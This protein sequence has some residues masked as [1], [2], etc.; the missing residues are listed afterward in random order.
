[1]NAMPP[2]WYPD[3]GLRPVVR[4]WDGTRWTDQTLSASTT[5]DSGSL[6][7][8]L[9]AWGWVLIAVVSTALLAALVTTTVVPRLRSAPHSDREL[10]V[11]TAPSDDPVRSDVIPELVLPPGTT[12]IDGPSSG[13]V[14]YWRV[15]LPHAEVVDR[16][17][18][19]LPVGRPYGRLAWCGES[20]S[21]RPP[22]GSVDW[23]WGTDP[24]YLGVLIQHGPQPDYTRVSIGFDGSPLACHR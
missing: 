14:E 4:Y 9:P 21:D 6:K 20:V 2:G 23:M 22:N 17:R 19:Q 10:S 13:G 12:R 11:N 18:V 8:S 5:S 16:L 15:P 3:P 24:D 1:M 7:T